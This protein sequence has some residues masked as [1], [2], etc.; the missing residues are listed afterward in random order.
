MLLYKSS[1]SALMAN[2]FDND[3]MMV[4]ER[5]S[6]SSFYNFSSLPSL[7]VEWG[8][9]AQLRCVKVSDPPYHTSSP[10]E[11]CS[12]SSR[13]QYNSDKKRR[14]TDTDC[15]DNNNGIV[16]IRKKL[17]VDFCEE[18]NQMQAEFFKQSDVV[19]NEAKPWNLRIKRAVVKD[20]NTLENSTHRKP[21]SSPVKPSVFKLPPKKNKYEIGNFEGPRAKFSVSLSKREI[22]EDFLAI[23]EHRPAR[24]PKKRSKNLQ[25]RFDEFNPGFWLTEI[26]AD[27]YKVNKQ[28]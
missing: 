8:R 16:G 4:P 28:I 11:L 18:A 21:N 1:V 2:S 22:E 13:S 10:L 17:M 9:Q 12:S 7:S 25:R 5:S 6:R 3:V 14:S 24:R 27:M 19:S 20:P 23:T 15:E 26:T